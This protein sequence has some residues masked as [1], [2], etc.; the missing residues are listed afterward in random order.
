LQCGGDGSAPPKWPTDPVLSLFGAE[1]PV[2]ATSC[3]V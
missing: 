1:T 2:E 3:G